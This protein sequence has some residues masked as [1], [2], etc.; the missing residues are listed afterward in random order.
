MS[1]EMWKSAANQEASP[2]KPLIAGASYGELE[3]EITP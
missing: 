3:I 1:L 2:I